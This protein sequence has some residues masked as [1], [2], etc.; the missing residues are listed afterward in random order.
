VS[1]AWHGIE[2]M[3]LNAACHVDSCGS[4]HVLALVPV[5]AVIACELACEWMKLL[6][7]L[8]LMAT[9]AEHNPL[10]F[11]AS[12][13]SRIEQNVSLLC[14]ADGTEHYGTT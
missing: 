2:S 11:V 7:L 5:L 12:E 1:L 10:T 3:H 6:S 14:M 4:H 8:M 9:R 13:F